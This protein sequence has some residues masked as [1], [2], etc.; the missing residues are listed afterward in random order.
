MAPYS[1]TCGLKYLLSSHNFFWHFLA[2]RQP[3]GY[4]ICS[5]IDPTIYLKL[6]LKI[7]GA[8]EIG[9]LILNTLIFLR[10]NLFKQKVKVVGN[11]G[12]KDLFLK[13]VEVESL[14]SFTT[15]LVNLFVLSIGI[16]NM[17][18]VNSIDGSNVN[19]YPSLHLVPIFHISNCS[20]TDGVAL[21]CDVLLSSRLLEENCL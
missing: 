19:K 7:Y 20:F 2:P 10:I 16:V 11:S 17:T 21:H 13:D 5:G 15:N 6:P 1:S 4:Y 9:S 18:I 8:L 12:R 3:L 14:T